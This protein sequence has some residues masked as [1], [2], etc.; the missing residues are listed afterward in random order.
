M[1]NFN[2]PK[3]EIVRIGVGYD[4]IKDHLKR[5]WDI[6]IPSDPGLSALPSGHLKTLPPLQSLER[7]VAAH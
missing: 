3:P 1:I 7:L 5:F 2:G 6:D 4:V